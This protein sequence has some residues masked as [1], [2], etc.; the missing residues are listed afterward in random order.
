MPVAPV[1][2]VTPAPAVAPV[3][4]VPLVLLRGWEPPSS[5]YAAGHRGVDLAAVPGTAV[6]AV[7]AGLVSYAG[8]VAGRGVLSIALTGT[9]DPPL[10]TTYE[11]VR[12]L[13]AEG[14]EVAAGQV[15]AVLADGPFHCPSGCL[16][17]GLRRADEYVNPL[18]LLRRGPSRLLPVFEVPEPFGVG[19]PA[20]RDRGP[21]RGRGRS[22]RPG[23]K[24][25]RAGARDRGPTVR[26]S[27]SPAVRQCG[28]G[29]PARRSVGQWPARVRRS[30][31][32][33]GAP[34]GRL[35]S[36]SR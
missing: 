13:V 30:R 33:R 1:G 10:R 18:S 24:V 27:G 20:T 9:G 25:R 36:A 19:E 34:S 32:R 3:P 23:A 22:R 26:R 29:G 14:E 5:P 6:R 21:R 12:P 15:V 31:R 16:H 11:P 17:W 8:R 7:R 35:G 2:P 28:A 4:P